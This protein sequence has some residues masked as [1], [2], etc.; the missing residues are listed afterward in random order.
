MFAD[1]WCDSSAPISLKLRALELSDAKIEE[2]A[3]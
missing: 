1:K 3:I 2:T